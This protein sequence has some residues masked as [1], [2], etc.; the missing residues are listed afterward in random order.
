MTTGC[1]SAEFVL[2]SLPASFL[3]AATQ[4]RT[5]LCPVSLLQ[6]WGKNSHTQ[7]TKDLHAMMVK[8]YKACQKTN[9]YM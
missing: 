6:Q 8:K 4:L 7:V 2:C 5:P 1:A 9:L 3:A